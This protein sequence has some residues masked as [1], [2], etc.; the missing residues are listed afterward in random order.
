MQC[1]E[2][3][4][5]YLREHQ[6]PFQVQQGV[7]SYEATT[8]SRPHASRTNTCS[9]AGSLCQSSRCAGAGVPSGRGAG[10]L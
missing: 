4:E 5:A 8:I 1:K 3:L 6:V 7:S 10:R 2:R 9:A